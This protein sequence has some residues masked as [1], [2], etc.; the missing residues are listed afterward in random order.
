MRNNNNSARPNSA[1]GL[2]EEKTKTRGDIWSVPS[3]LI[4]DLVVASPRDSG[5]CDRLSVSSPPSISP[6]LRREGEGYVE[7]AG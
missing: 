2:R 6:Y 1:V 7:G 3:A 5:G 4:L